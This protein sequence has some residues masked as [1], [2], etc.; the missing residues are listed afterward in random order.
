M[1]ILVIGAGIIG[2]TTAYH[3]ARAEHQ[4]TVVERQSG[5][6]N[7]CSHANGGFLSAAYCAPWAAP[8]VSTLALRSLFTSRSPMRWRPDFTLR[9]LRWLWATLRECNAARFV[10][11]HRRMLALGRYS[12]AC[13]DEME[14]ATGLAFERCRN[15][16][17]QPCHSAADLVA[18]QRLARNLHAE[19]MRA[20]CLSR[21][22]TL[23]RE[24]ALASQ[25]LG[26]TGAL[27]IPDEGS[28][29]CER[30]TT[31]L[32][33]WLEQRGTH[34]HWNARVDGLEIG[35]ANDG[36]SRRFEGV[37]IDDRLLRADACVLAAGPETADLLSGHLELPVYPVKG[38]SMTAPVVNES[39]APRH[40]VLDAHGRL[41]IARLG[42]AIRVA[43]F[44]EVVGHDTRQDAARCAQLA[45]AL[46]RL[47]PGAIDVRNARF[48][49][50][51]RP[52]TPDGTPIVGAS[53]ID[54][55]YLNTGHGS[56]GW[57]MS[58]GSARLLSDI[59]SGR[60]TAL[61][62]ADYAPGRYD[63][64]H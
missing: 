57:T 21:E 28:G 50:G 43:G 56:Y 3:L 38:Y 27:H 6:A 4:V 46:E 19:G 10:I 63:L 5:A 52:T 9:Q 64:T 22:E 42:E 30:F 55:L 35:I 44:A 33:R 12:L 14:K 8:G 26:L 18:A 31:D 60:A 59:V 62:A 37:R 7:G 13:L 58:C 25:A 41:A 17:L 39:L 49:A 40:A 51:L 29:N 34:F 36:R 20:V 24:P 32:A 1:K 15:G 48:W 16:I 11:N 2:I 45:D 61:P 54:G 47:Y 23:T 53:D